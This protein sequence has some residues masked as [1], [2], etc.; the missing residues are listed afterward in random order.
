M[1]SKNNFHASFHR[2]FYMLLTFPVRIFAIESNYNCSWLY[3]MTLATLHLK[4]LS[5]HEAT[6]LYSHCWGDHVFLHLSIENISIT[7][8]FQ[9]AFCRYLWALLLHWDSLYEY[10]AKISVLKFDYQG[11]DWERCWRQYS[12]IKTQ[13]VLRKAIS[14]VLLTK[15]FW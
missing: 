9:I 15:C 6:I 13:F 7:V 3:W 4:Y 11:R 1:R 14:H 10:V 8:C 5:N 2:R 12:C